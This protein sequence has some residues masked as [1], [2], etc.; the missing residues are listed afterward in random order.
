MR[1]RARSSSGISTVGRVALSAASA[2][3]GKE[4]FDLLQEGLR[5]G[6]AGRWQGLS[7]R[8]RA[9]SPGGGSARPAGWPAPERAWC[10]VFAEIEHAVQ[11]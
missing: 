9:L 3:L 6:A 2:T 11:R 8:P 1:P 4:G 10:R 7:G 5:G